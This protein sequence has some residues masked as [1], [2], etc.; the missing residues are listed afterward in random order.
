VNHCSSLL[1]AHTQLIEGCRHP[2]Q[3]A[4]GSGPVQTIFTVSTAY[5]F[6]PCLL[7]CL[8]SWYCGSGG[9]APLLHVL[10]CKPAGGQHLLHVEPV[11]AWYCQ[12][13]GLSCALF[14][15]LLRS[16]PVYWLS[17]AV[18]ELWFKGYMCVVAVT[19][20]VSTSV[21]GNLAIR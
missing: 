10:A 15:F 11:S 17:G 4:S 2:L 9:I 5:W 18:F 13:P 12:R 16:K 14:C 7:L 19:C 1:L 20:A 3:S 21:L 8:A 6:I